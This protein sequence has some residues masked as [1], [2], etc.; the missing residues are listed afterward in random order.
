MNRRDFLSLRVTRHGKVLEL[1]CQRL[2]MQTLAAE[3]AAG[4]GYDAATDYQPWM[5]EPPAVL[6]APSAES[7]IGQLARDLHEVDRVRVLESEWLDS[8]TLGERLAP[9]L[10]SFRARGG[11]VELAERLSEQPHGS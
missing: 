11:R 8:T 4:L 6:E 5:G 3:A 10:A 7:L 1:S 2:Y 9:L